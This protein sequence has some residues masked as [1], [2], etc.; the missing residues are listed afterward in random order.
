[1]GDHARLENRIIALLFW[2]VLAAPLAMQLYTGS[3]ANFRRTEQRRVSPLPGL[4]DS[5]A[6]LEKYPA[7]LEA[8]FDDR[9]GFRA[10]LIYAHNFVKSRFG[11]SPDRKAIIGRE[12][13]LFVNEARLLDANRG[14]WP[15]RKR[16]LRELIRLFE[17][18]QTALAAAGIY[19]LQVA[20]PDKQSVYPEYLPE[21]LH[22]VGPS[23]YRQF[24]EAVAGSTINFVDSYGPLLAAKQRGEK[25]YFQT[26]SHWT[27]RGAFI[28][29]RAIMEHVSNR[30]A[31]GFVELGENDVEFSFQP[32]ASGFDLAR[33]VIGAPALFPDAN[34][35]RCF[36]TPEP[37]IAYSGLGTGTAAR[38]G[39]L[40]EARKRWLARNADPRLRLRVLVF[41]DSYSNALI[42]Y[43]DASFREVAYV[44]HGALALD[45]DLV[46]EFKPDIVIYEHVERTLAYAAMALRAQAHRK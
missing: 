16:E 46:N 20:P 29:Y 45:M 26:D 43:L 22:R 9:F 31:D 17:S 25:I 3:D 19:Y 21:R 15:F 11:V 23:R 35:G 13:W 5:L 7:A 34:A 28:A 44:P 4:P 42:N 40:Y 14:A 33:N 38:L 24:L 1:M 37:S 2:L 18:R 6:Q 12:G 41:R 27:C 8:W 39:D 10:Q 36:I 32:T 30:F